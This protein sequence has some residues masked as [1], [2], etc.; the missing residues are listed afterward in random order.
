MKQL[1]KRREYQ[2]KKRSTMK[3]DKEKMP[4]KM[5]YIYD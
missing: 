5:K 4:E 1:K 2:I 3:N